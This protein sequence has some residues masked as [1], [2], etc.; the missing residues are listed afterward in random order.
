VTYSEASQVTWWSGRDCFLTIGSSAWHGALLWE[1]W[2]F[3]WARQAIRLT[4]TPYALQMTVGSRKRLIAWHTLTEVAVF[5]HSCPPLL[6]FQHD[7]T[8]VALVTPT[9]SAATALARL[10]LSYRGQVR[11][12]NQ[13]PELVD[14]T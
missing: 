14:E 5:R 11:D 3:W 8:G 4:F 12:S 1:H 2:G 7:G 6:M 10:C 13:T 9:K